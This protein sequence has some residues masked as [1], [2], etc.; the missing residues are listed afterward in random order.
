[1]QGLA[2]RGLTPTQMALCLGISRS[3]FYRKQTDPDFAQAIATGKAR[4]LIFASGKLWEMAMKSRVR[5]LIFFCK[6]MGWGENRVAHVHGPQ[7]I[8]AVKREEEKAKSAC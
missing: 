2:E 3:T 4:L 7:C 8:P 5:P 1:V 6:K